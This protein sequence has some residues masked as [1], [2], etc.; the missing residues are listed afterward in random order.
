[1]AKNIV[2]PAIGKPLETI[3]AL[4]TYPTT[5]AATPVPASGDPVLVCGIPGVAETA[6]DLASP[7]FTTCN[8]KK[9][10]IVE[11]PVLGDD[12]A[13]S[14]VAAGNILYIGSTGIVSKL[15][16]GVRFGIAYRSK[17]NPST[18]GFTGTGTLVLSGATTTIQVILGY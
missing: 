9:G 17:Q 1:M 12:G 7:Y 8:V 16:T 14:A 2:G 11:V 3:K 18:G 10:S 13:G 6:P 4:V 5:V 15:N